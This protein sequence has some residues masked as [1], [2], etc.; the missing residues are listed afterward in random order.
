MSNHDGRRHHFELRLGIRCLA[1]L[2]GASLLY[3]R[4]VHRKTFRRLDCRSGISNAAAVYSAV[5]IANSADRMAT[6]HSLP[7]FFGF[8]AHTVDPEGLTI[9]NTTLPGHLLYPGTV[10]REVQERGDEIWIVSKGYGNGILPW[11]N[12]RFAPGLF[13][14]L[15]TMVALTLRPELLGEV[16]K[17]AWNQLILRQNRDPLILWTS[18]ETASS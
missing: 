6:G 9:T 1:R 3:R 15:D 5:A 8:V 10:F 2:V 17:V 11:F 18:M 16:L 4:D 14:L 13:Q 12:E 7:L